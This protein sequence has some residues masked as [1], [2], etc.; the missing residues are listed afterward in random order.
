[1]VQ[2]EDSAT[3]AD[4]APAWPDAPADAAVRAGTALSLTIQ[5]AERE[6]PVV[7][8]DPGAGWT[9]SAADHAAITLRGIAFG[10][11]GWNGMAFPPAG[12]I[13][14]E[15]CTILDFAN[16]LRFVA[17]AEGT[18]VAV[19]R[20]ETAALALEGA[21]ELRLADS[22]ADAFPATVLRAPAGIVALDRVSVRGDVRVR[23]IEASEAIFDGRVEVQDRFRG[24]VRYSRVPA[25]ATLPR[26]HRVTVG[27]PIRVVSRNRRDAAWWRLRE[28]CDPAIARGAE[29]GSEM[30]A[31]GRTMLGQ[32]LES[33]A[34]R[35]GEYTPAGLL[36]GIV[37]ID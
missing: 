15:F 28:D 21:G 8:I 14:L 10:G 19:T 37:R 1:V 29:N 24:C 30:G 5:A 12:E 3:Y 34:R 33:F 6:R 9:S 22:I 20:C 16:E 25:D 36:T 35:L 17:R 23:A 31:F 26:V 11:P 13:A 4:E 32:R 2:F 7:V 27:T 18:R